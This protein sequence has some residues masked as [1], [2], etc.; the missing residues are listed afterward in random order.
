LLGAGHQVAAFVIE[1]R[2]G[3]GLIPG[4]RIVAAQDQQ[5]FDPHRG[6]AEQVGLQGNAVAVAA[7]ELQ[8]RFDPGLQQ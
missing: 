5:V 1:H 8:H 3:I 7:G 6:A 2:L 4:R